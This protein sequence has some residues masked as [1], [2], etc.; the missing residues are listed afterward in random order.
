REAHQAMLRERTI[1]QYQPGKDIA[2]PAIRPAPA[3]ETA[4]VIQILSVLPRG[5][6]QRVSAP[7]ALISVTISGQARLWRN[8]TLGSGGLPFNRITPLGVS[9]CISTPKLRANRSATAAFGWKKGMLNA[10][11]IFPTV[12]KPT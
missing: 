12:K 2:T 6:S 4:V 1:S 11:M 8:I 10:S 3:P 7:V 5:T 9:P